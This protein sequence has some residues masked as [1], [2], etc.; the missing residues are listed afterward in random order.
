MPVYEYICTYCGLSEVRI[1]GIDDHRAKCPVCSRDMRRDLEVEDL[2]ASYRTPAK[3][4][5]TWGVQA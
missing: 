1:G 2:L 3:R 5:G 4:P